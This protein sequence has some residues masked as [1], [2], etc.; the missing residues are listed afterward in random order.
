MC[1]NKPLLLWWYALLYWDALRGQASAS[2]RTEHRSRGPGGDRKGQPAAARRASGRS[3][4]QPAARAPRITTHDGMHPCTSPCT[5]HPAPLLV[6]LVRRLVATLFQQAG[7][8]I[9]APG[10]LETD[11]T[12]DV[13][14]TVGI[15]GGWRREW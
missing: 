3:R 10:D 7:S 15:A 1:W 14:G 9:D 6:T 12:F 5:L 13:P 2:S 4:A 11:G 8:D